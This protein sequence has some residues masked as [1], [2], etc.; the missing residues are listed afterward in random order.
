MKQDFYLLK[1]MKQIARVCVHAR[2]P[3]EHSLNDCLQS[4]IAIRHSFGNKLKIQLAC[5]AKTN[6]I[7]LTLPY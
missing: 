7:A 6:R 5:C 1:L 3:K 4:W 2:F